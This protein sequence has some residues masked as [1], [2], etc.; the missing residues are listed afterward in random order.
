MLCEWRL[1]SGSRRYAELS[2]YMGIDD[3]VG[4]LCVVGRDGSAAPQDCTLV[5]RRSNRDRLGSRHE[6]G[7]QEKSVSTLV[8]ERKQ[9][10]LRYVAEA[11]TLV[12]MS[13]AL[14]HLPEGC[15]PTGR[16]IPGSTAEERRC[17]WLLSDQSLG[18]GAVARLTAASTSRKI[19]FSCTFPADGGARAP[20]SCDGESAE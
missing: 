13:V 1:R 5:Q 15:T 14:G 9:A 18:H 4:M 10:A 11:R 16:G 19:Q 2:R 17:T 20:E 7:K 6:F 3:Q 8:E 12:E